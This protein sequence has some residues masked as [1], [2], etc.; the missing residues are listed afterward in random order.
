MWVFDGEEWT[1][2]GGNEHSRTSRPE[3]ARPRYDEMT[4]ELQVIEIVIPV[5]PRRTNVPPLPMP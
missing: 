2:D 5:Q 4:P 3:P 1:Q